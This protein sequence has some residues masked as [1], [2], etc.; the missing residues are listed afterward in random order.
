MGN[1]AVTRGV[2]VPVWWSYENR[3]APSALPPLRFCCGLFSTPC[4]CVGF[5]LVDIFF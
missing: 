3:E 4:A 5:L 2:G 1:K